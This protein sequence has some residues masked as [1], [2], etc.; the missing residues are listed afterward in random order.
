MKIQLRDEV[1][2]FDDGV[3]VADIAKSI[4][5]GL[6]R[7]AVCGKINDELVDLDYK[8]NYDCALEIITNKSEEYKEVLRHSAAHVLA[9]AVKTI[10]PNTKC[11][12]GP[13]T[14]DGFYYDFDFK[15]PITNDD[16]KTIEAEM[17]KIIKANFDIVRKE[18]DHAMDD[19][20]YF[21]NTVLDKVF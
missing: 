7:V 17:N 18:N 6:A 20:R 19:I 11:W 2:E 8:I 9:Q 13:A 10:Y 3:S 16:L 5:E 21:V 4:S 1:R 14:K 12:V 15:T